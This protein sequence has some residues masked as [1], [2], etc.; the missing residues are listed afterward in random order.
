MTS[1]SRASHEPDPKRNCLNSHPGNARRRKLPAEGFRGPLQ[2]TRLTVAL[3]GEV[4]FAQPLCTI[5]RAGALRLSSLK[6]LRRSSESLRILQNNPL[7]S[8][9]SRATA[10][11]FSDDQLDDVGG[12]PEHHLQHVVVLLAT[13]E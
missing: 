11:C 12:A 5:A 10:R 13:L 7:Q 8:K 3:D 6:A 2:D 1:L 4:E 9:R